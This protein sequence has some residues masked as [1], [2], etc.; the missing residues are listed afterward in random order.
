MATEMRRYVGDAIISALI[1]YDDSSWAVRNSATM[2]FAAAMLRAVDA[3]KNA[4]N[5]SL[6]YVVLSKVRIKSLQI[7]IHLSLSKDQ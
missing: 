4:A 6:E 5:T 3:D 2:T 7:F 1:G